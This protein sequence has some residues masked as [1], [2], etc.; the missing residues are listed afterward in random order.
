MTFSRHL[1]TCLL[2]TSGVSADVPTCS[3]ASYQLVWQDEFEGKQLDMTRWGM[4]GYKKREAAT[5]NGEGTIVVSDG[6]L[7]LNAFE[8]DGEICCAIIDTRH[9]FERTY[10]WYEARM[11]MHRLGGMHSCFWLQTPTFKKFPDAP[12]QSGTE[13]DIMEWFGPKRRSGWAGMN[14]YYFGEKGNVRSPSIPQFHLMGGPVEGDPAGPLADMSQDFHI[15][16]MHWTAEAC[17]FYCDGIEIMRETKVIS[18]VPEYI[19]LSLLC[20]NWERPRLEVAKL[21]DALQIDYVRVYAPRDE[22]LPPSVTTS[23]PP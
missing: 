5:I 13:M 14:V 8:K 4:P 1:L 11:K 10:G 6:V 2:L 12:E 7:K 23:S 18:A 20:S 16:A 3:P 22:T 17:I 21:P 19:V 9:K 15:Y